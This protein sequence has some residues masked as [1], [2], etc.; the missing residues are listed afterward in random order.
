MLSQKM[1][2]ELLLI[3]NNLKSDRN[4]NS[5]MSGGELFKRTLHNLIKNRDNL[6]DKELLSRVLNVKRLWL[7]YQNRLLN[8]D[9]S[10][11]RR[12]E[13]MKRREEVADRLTEELLHI[14]NR[15]D[16]KIYKR[17]LIDTAKMFNMILNGLIDGN[18]TSVL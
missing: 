9:F 8:T 5:L 18:S 3:A 15:V 13:T 11:E 12:A 14:A 17:Q 10:K 4:R 16:E 7:E 1:A 2:K 6:E